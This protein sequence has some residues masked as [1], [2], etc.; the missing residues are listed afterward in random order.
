MTPEVNSASSEYVKK[1]VYQVSPL[2][3]WL[4]IYTLYTLATALRALSAESPHKIALHKQLNK[5]YS[6]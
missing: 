5:I 1:P 4:D 6:R 3:N 2:Y